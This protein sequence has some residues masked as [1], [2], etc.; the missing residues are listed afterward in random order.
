MK[1]A[2]HSN[3]DPKAILQI[4]KNRFPFIYCFLCVVM[5]AV[6]WLVHFLLLLF[7]AFGFWFFGDSPGY[8][9]P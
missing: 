8:P 5:V 6:V 3:G 2:I 4:P 1:M 7:V 9:R